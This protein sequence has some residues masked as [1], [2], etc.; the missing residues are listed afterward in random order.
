MGEYCDYHVC[1]SVCLSVC[2]YVCLL[3]IRLHISGITCPNFTKFSVLQYVNCGPG[4]V[5]LL[6][7]C[8]TLCASGF[9][10]DFIRGPMARHVDSNAAR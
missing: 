1:G 3:A 6:R 4:S 2:H 8:D 5:L 9:E 10:D 7:R